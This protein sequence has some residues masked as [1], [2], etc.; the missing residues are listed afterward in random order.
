MHRTTRGLATGAIALSLLIAGSV[1]FAGQGF[2]G[3]REGA[4]GRGI[5][6][7]LASLD[8]T[9][10]QKVKV[11]ELLEAE[12]PKYEALR[13]EGRTA[14]EALRTAAKAATPDPAAVGAAFLRVDAH[15]DAMRAERESSRKQLAGLLTPEQRARL[16]GFREGRRDL[17]R[18][19]FGPGSRGGRSGASRPSQG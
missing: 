3:G 2:R 7:A 5:R 12:K 14:R 11:K 4:P 18:G 8:L 19:A 15:R 16:E 6:A 13:E 10:A 17:R 1:A 9:D